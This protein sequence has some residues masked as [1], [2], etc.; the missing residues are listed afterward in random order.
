MLGEALL[1]QSPGAW[2]N[3]SW[4][5]LGL[6]LLTSTTLSALVTTAPTSPLHA[7]HGDTTFR[8][9]QGR[10]S[11]KIT[12]WA[13]EGQSVPKDHTRKQ[14]KNT[15]P[16]QNGSEVVPACQKRNKSKADPQNTESQRPVIPTQASFER[17][18]GENG[19]AQGFRGFFQTAENNL[20]FLSSFTWVPS[21][22]QVRKGEHLV[23]SLSR[24]M[25]RQ[26]AV[27]KDQLQLLLAITR[28]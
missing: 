8:N 14:K 26:E 5:S 11:W 10:Y 7:E 27:D 2:P 17:L 1:G 6:F 15:G 19:Q 23:L 4:N 16:D 12:F 22:S 24:A 13:W 3:T 18:E 20:F 9:Q 21:V 25:T 28:S